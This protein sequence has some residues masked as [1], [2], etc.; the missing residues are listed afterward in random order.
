LITSVRHGILAGLLGLQTKFLAEVSRNST[1]TY[2]C[3]YFY[4]FVFKVFNQNI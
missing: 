4:L 1:E 3:T 2:F